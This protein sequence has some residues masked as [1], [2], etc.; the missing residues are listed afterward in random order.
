MK[1]L[2]LMGMLCT[3]QFLWAQTIQVKGRVLDENGVPVNG[4][5]VTVKNSNVSTVSAAD[6]SF[7][8]NAPVNATL[9]VSYVGYKALDVPAS[10]AA[11]IRL[12]QGENRLS[13]VVV[14]GYGQSSKKELTSSVVKVK[15]AEVANT[16][17]TNFQQALQG[18]AAGVFV[19]SQNGKL[20][21]GVK[22]RIRGQGSINASNDPLYVIDGIPVNT[23][24]LS[25][26]AMADINFNDVESFDVL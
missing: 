9:V 18:R 22:L 5:T 20:G 17:V 7:T 15:G 25:G 21:E 11:S 23:G 4:A 13:E 12:M 14:V 2:L 26:N 6:G 10:A 3:I 19:E 8:I 1:Y 16:P 24:N